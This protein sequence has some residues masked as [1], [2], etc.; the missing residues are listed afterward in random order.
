M[1]M[2]KK[3]ERARRVDTNLA[4]N[5]GLERESSEMRTYTSRWQVSRQRTLTP[6][7]RIQRKIR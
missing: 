7:R 5:V 3:C 4:P 6:K 1:N 2:R